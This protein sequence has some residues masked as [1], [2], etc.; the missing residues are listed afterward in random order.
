MWPSVNVTYYYNVQG[1]GALDLIW[2]LSLLKGWSCPML[3]GAQVIML[4]R[5][6]IFRVAFHLLLQHARIHM[7][8]YYNGCPMLQARSGKKKLNKTM[9]SIGGINWELVHIKIEPNVTGTKFY[10]LPYLD[11][12]VKL[13]G[14]IRESEVLLNC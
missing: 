8:Q 14:V 13:T 11:V 12:H 5:M 3:G 6:C 1:P 2:E 7:Q 4:R 10:D 9:C